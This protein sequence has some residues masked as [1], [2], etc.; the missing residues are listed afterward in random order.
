MWMYILMILLALICAVLLL[1]HY[2]LGRNVKK[3]IQ[4]ARDMR[5]GNFNLRFRLR[6]IRKDMQELSGEMNRLADFFQGALERT[7]FLEEERG[8]MIS[9]ISHDLRTPL[10]SLLGYIDALQNDEMLTAEEKKNFLRIAAEK[11]NGLLGLIQEF[12]ELARLEE[13]PDKTVL[14]RID[15]AELARVVLLDFYPDFTK[16]SITPSVSIPD[17]PVYVNANKDYLRRVLN[18]LLSNALR[19]GQEGKEIGITVRRKAEQAFVDIW[20]KGKGIPQKDL[21]HIFERL[22]TAEA[23]RNASMRG[24]GLGLTI[25]KGLIEKQGGQITAESIPG[26]K[27]VFSF[28]LNVIP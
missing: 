3:I 10:T 14:Q 11:G 4:T 17:Q 2:H 7:K 21:P 27:T 15:L 28:C 1:Q 13:E 24:T 18:N 19:Y 12:F 5:A 20:D 6:T 16:L 26:E 25:A 23:S 8:R 22:Y 9:N